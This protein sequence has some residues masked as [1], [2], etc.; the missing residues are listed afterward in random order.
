VDSSAQ[1]IVKAAT[2]II[3]E[4]AMSE[5]E[6]VMMAEDK[7]KQDL[8]ESVYDMEQAISLLNRAVSR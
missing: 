7:E 1:N 6:L 4:V 3:R 5:K 8:R 2:E